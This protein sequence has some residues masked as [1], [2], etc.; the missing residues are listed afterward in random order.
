MNQFWRNVKTNHHHLSSLISA[1][2]SKNSDLRPYAEITLEG[3]KHLGLLD[4]GAQ[5]SCLGNKL[6]VEIQNKLN[7]TQ[8][9]TTIRTADSREQL[10][11]GTVDLPI[12]FKNEK[13]ILHF[14][15]VPSLSQD[16]ILGVD[17]WKKFQIA[18]NIISQVDFEEKLGMATTEDLSVHVLCPPEKTRLEQVKSLFP[19][20]EKEG[21]GRTKLFQYEIELEPNVRPIKQRYFPISPAIE[22]LVHKE[23]DEMLALG[24]IE[25]APNSPWSSPVVLVKKPNKVRL[26]LDS[27]KVNK[28]TVK[29]AYPLPHIDGIISRLPKAEYI[30]SLDLRRAFWQIPLAESSKD[31]T[32]F[33]VP[34]RPLYRYVVMPFGLCNAPQ[35]LCRLM[36]RVIPN[37]LRDEVF[38]YLDDLLIVSDTFEKHM[39]VLSTVAIKLREAGLTINVEKSKFCLKEVKYLGFVVG[40]GTLMVDKDKVSAVTD[41]P[42]PTTVR[43]LRRFLGMAG[44]YRRF[45]GDYA[46]ITAPLTNLL[47]KGRGFNW[48]SEADAAFV[49]LKEK[50]SSA[51][52]LA[53]PDYSKAFI[54]QCDA[55]KQ[56]VGAVLS[57][58]NAEGVE[59]PIA[60]FSKKLNKAQSN[61]SVT[62]Q[63]CLAVV[64]S[65]KKFRAYIEGQEFQVITDHASLQWLMRQTDLSGRLARWALKLQGYRFEIKHR[66]GSEN[67]VPDCLSRANFE[68]D[69]LSYFPQIDMESNHFKSESYEKLIQRVS[70]DK[71]ALPDL[72]VIAGKVYK[73]TD[74]S[75]GDP[76]KEGFSW[77]LWVPE[78][79]TQEIIEHAHKPPQKCH[80][81]IGKTI[82]RI[83]LNFYWPDLAIRVKEFVSNCEEC[84]TSK[85]PNYVL[86]P[87]MRSPYVVGRPF[88][89]IYIDLLGPYPRSKTGHI[90]LLIVLDHLTKFPLLQPLKKF[91]TLHILNFLS[92]HVFPVYGTPNVL[93]S[94][95][96]K[97]FKNKVF[98]K[99]LNDR[100]VTH[101]Y[102]ALYSP[103][104]NASERVNRSVICGIRTYLGKDQTVWD[105]NIPEIAESLRSSYHQTIGCSPYFALFGQQMATHGHDYVVFRQLHSLEGETVD[106]SDRLCMIRKQITDNVAKAFA[107]SSKRYNLRSNSSNHF[108]E[109]DVVYRRNFCQSDA[110]KKFTSKFAPRFIKAKVVC[111]KGTC[112]YE[113]EDAESKKREV[114]HGKDIKPCTQPGNPF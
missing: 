71:M 80:G 86:R 92:E 94:D 55:S 101:V 10:C 108:K 88:E 54:L 37:S 97:Q 69:E 87:P 74:F 78:G 44:W 59:V 34:N 64:L 8:R 102:T 29:D 112:M 85:S 52:I 5:V 72:Q 43:Q 109:G 113:L 66:R 90:G 110:T 25:E 20:C 26:C 36:D 104:A 42:A 12:T 51:P 46:A 16:I 58:V 49:E 60:Y 84:Q 99:F 21:L 91:D 56:G 62:E 111:K 14:F 18:P 22:K 61:Y 63:E 32:C 77:K 11:F 89:K 79:L 4:S 2:S 48:S 27:R 31:Y 15:V 57:Q 47:R 107:D 6:A 95:N 28:V 1:I 100:G 83:K 19:S 82:R 68:I 103:Q 76:L 41:F 50:L 3:S 17:F 65:L 35:A 30:S 53:S 93:L 33:T 24:V 114:Y 40:N 105:R 45:I 7:L 98:N 96:G 81:G 67:I 75:D 73:R 13:K 9:K 23:I 106:R 39:S 38:V 70:E